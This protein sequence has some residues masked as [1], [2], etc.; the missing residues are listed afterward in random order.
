MSVTADDL[1]KALFSAEIKGEKVAGTDLSELL[2]ITPS[3]V[4]RLALKL[5]GEGMIEY[6]RYQ[7][8][9]LTR[10]GREAA[11]MLIRKHRLWEMFLFKVL[12]MP[13]EEVHTEA[14]LL[15][16]Q[17]TDQMVERLDDFL[18]HPQYDPHGQPI[19]DR[20]GKV[21]SSK[22]QL[23]LSEVEPGKSYTV[24]RVSDRSQALINYFADIG[25]TLHARIT[26]LD[27]IGMDGS[28]IVSVKN[29]KTIVSPAMAKNIFV[30]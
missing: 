16:H 4:T 19:P 29:N 22:G 27:K 23:R 24:T 26:V 5:A 25:L 17:T 3:G 28:L 18:G 2:G 7:G 9:E 21:P 1:L 20:N 14:E 12:K 11:A 13:W 30:E 10:K 8:I 6:Q 15:E